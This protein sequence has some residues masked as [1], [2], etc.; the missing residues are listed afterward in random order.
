MMCVTN[1]EKKEGVSSRASAL[2][3]QRWRPRILTPRSRLQ[4]PCPA[5]LTFVVDAAIGV[6][7][8]SHQLLHLI[9]C[10]PLTWQEWKAESALLRCEGWGA[11]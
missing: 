9:F 10:Q 2:G 6:L 7:L 4:T 8:P 1:A 11:P 5:E 3:S